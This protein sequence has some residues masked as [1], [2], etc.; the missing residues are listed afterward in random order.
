MASIGL[1]YGTDEG[2]TEDV[3]K[4]IAARFA[5]GEV[6]IINIAE[7]TPEDFSRFGK[8]ILGTPTLENGGKQ[9]DWEMFWPNL[10]SI[11]FSEKTVA[12]F[13]LGDQVGYGDFFLDAMGDL[14]EAV[15]AQGASIVGDWPAEGYDFVASR[16]VVPGGDRFVGLA[17]DEDTQSELTDERV[18]AWVKQI[19]PHFA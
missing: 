10:Y 12:I 5:D 9:Q 6:E 17:I 11:D 19:S 1:F 18:E 16:G 8:L 4:R 2:H 7:A 3:A 14:F 15:S 13:G